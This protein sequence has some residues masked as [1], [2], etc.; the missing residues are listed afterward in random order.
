V[1][2]VGGYNLGSVFNH[3]PDSVT[4][5]VSSDLWHIQAKARTSGPAEVHCVT[6]VGK[7]RAQTEGVWEQGAEGNIWT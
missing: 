7:G 5:F 4:R 1:Y 6:S 2:C 3:A